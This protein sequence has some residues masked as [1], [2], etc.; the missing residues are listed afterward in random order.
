MPNNSLYPGFAK[1]FY[2]SN[3]HGHTH[4]VPIQ[5]PLDTGGGVWQIGLKGGG[6][7]LISAAFLTY[8]NVIKALF[9]VGA[10]IVHAELWTLSSPTADPIYQQDVNLA[11]A[12]TAFN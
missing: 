5:S 8:A 6:N 9:D 11:I 4:V 3:G 2:T 1:F 7:A 12:G 10:S